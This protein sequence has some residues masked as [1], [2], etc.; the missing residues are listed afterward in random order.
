VNNVAVGDIKER[1]SR[2]VD[3]CGRCRGYSE[4]DKI[5]E[6]EESLRSCINVEQI[7]AARRVEE[8]EV[9]EE[10]VANVLR[11]KADDVIFDFVVR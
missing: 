10:D 9:A 11:M 7:S 2:G 4:R 5:G 6:V 1:L 3:N 8:I